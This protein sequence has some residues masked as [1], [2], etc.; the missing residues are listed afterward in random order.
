M[1]QLLRSLS[2]V[3]SIGICHRDLKSENVLL[4]P[5]SGVLKLADFGSAKKLVEG[6]TNVYYICSRYCR[7][8]GYIN[9]FLISIRNI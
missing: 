5:E 8:P 1:Y 7:P 3:H 2:Y 4:D 6:E 9:I